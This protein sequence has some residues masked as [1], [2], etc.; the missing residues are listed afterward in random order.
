MICETHFDNVKNSSGERSRILHFVMDSDEDA[1]M[2]PKDAPD[3]SDAISKDK[4]YIK[5][6]GGWFAI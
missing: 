6:P 5:F 2:L 1:A 3:G 4:V